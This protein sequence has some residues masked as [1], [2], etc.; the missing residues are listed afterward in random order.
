M[1]QIAISFPDHP[2]HRFRVPKLNLNNPA[3]FEKRSRE[4]KCA[5]KQSTK[6]LVDC[7]EKRQSALNA[8][9]NPELIEEDI[10]FD[11]MHE[12][13]QLTTKQMKTD[14]IIFLCE[15]WIPDSYRTVLQNEILKRGA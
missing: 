14:D 7:F 4:S 13:T 12:I 8:F 6:L 15:Q 2:I 9:I 1:A 3:Y 10:V 11:K 5:S